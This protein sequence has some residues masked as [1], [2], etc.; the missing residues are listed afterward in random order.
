MVLRGV[1]N[2]DRP[3]KYNS[4]TAFLLFCMGYRLPSL[5]CTVFS[6]TYCRHAHWWHL[7]ILSGAT[8]SLVVTTRT[9]QPEDLT[10]PDYDT[11]ELKST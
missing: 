11:C 4:K 5:L 10:Q 3:E 1:G 7:V 2:V 9:V 8:A 6:Y